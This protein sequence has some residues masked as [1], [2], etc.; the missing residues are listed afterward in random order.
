MFQN[1]KWSWWK[2]VKNDPLWYSILS[3][4]VSKLELPCIAPVFGDTETKLPPRSWTLRL[5]LSQP[6][7]DEEQTFICVHY[8]YL[9]LLIF[10]VW[11]DLCCQNLSPFKALVLGIHRKNIGCPLRPQFSHE[12]SWHVKLIH[13]LL[14]LQKVCCQ[15]KHLPSLSFYWFISLASMM[16]TRNCFHANCFLRG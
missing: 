3:T 11:P 13:Y 15:V 2:N 1:L 12:G 9:H 5:E 8:L 6:P 10:G 14:G 4:W 16:G 7:S